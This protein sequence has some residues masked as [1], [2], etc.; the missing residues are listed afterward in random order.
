ML[1]CYVYFKTT[2]AKRSAVLHKIAE[3]GAVYI[4]NKL[5]KDLEIWSL[6][7]YLTWVPKA[8]QRSLSE[9]AGTPL[10]IEGHEARGVLFS[11]PNS[12]PNYVAIMPFLT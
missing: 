2:K 10:G 9:H 4:H 1:Y 5:Y 11:F 6:D 12:L 8:R 3:T 7:P